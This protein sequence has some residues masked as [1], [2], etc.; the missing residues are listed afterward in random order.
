MA[1]D[2][3]GVIAATTQWLTRSYPVTGGA[4]D[5]AL[6][7]AQA[8]QAVTAA[9]WLRYPSQ[10]DAALLELLGPGG[11]AALDRLT[12]SGA[13]AADVPGAGE[14]WRSWVDEVVA[15]WAACL[16]TDA[17][18]ARAAVAALDGCEHAAGLP[19]EFRRLTAPDPH[20]RHAAPLL[21][22][23]DLLAPV[24]ALHRSELLR[25]LSAGHAAETEAAA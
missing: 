25:R 16:L 10:A 17:P 11:S 2:L 24:A 19:F 4:L 1:A 9:A 15:S 14:A 12:G 18:L 23:P 3:S 5:A 13:A 6:A 7:Q 8:R 20:D 21:R 22:H